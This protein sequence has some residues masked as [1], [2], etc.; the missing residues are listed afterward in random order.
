MRF[1]RMLFGVLLLVGLGSL[2][3]EADRR[4]A[5]VIGNGDYKNAPHLPNPRHDAEDV[6]SALKRLDFETIAGFDLDQAGIDDATARFAR[7][8]RDADLALFYYSG[9]AMQHAGINYLMPVDARLVD[10]V[11]LRRM[12]RVDEIVS[13]LQQAKNLRILILDSCRDNPLADDLRRSS[14]TTRGAAIERGLARIESPQGMIVSYATQAGR[15]AADGTGRNSPFTAAFLKHVEEPEEIGTIFRR[16]S[17]DVYQSTR[18][19]QL[20]ELSL[21][22]V[23]EFYLNGR[24]TEYP[25]LSPP[26][27]SGARPPAGAFEAFYNSA[28]TRRK[29]GEYDGAIADF[30]MAIALNPDDPDSFYGRA[31]TYNLKGERERAIKDYDDAIRLHPSDATALNERCWT[32]AVIGQLQAALADCDR[33]LSLKP[34]SADALDS[35]GLANLKL[36]RLDQAITDYDAAL[37]LQPRKADSLYG[38]GL[39]RQHSGKAVAGNTDIA[40]AKAIRPGIV[41][42]FVRYGVR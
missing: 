41:E 34:D 7:A 1:P 21:S 8:A 23:G 33:S 24:R 2:P 35:R 13:D 10:E 6:A 27:V 15:T 22:L 29:Q 36:G 26:S 40:A 4:V 32:R 11:D 39:A 5:L 3:A 12:A 16:I 28:V 42:E 20:P 19:A 38:R 31:V 17:G 25:A 18:Q 9:H 14:G 30:D 37:R